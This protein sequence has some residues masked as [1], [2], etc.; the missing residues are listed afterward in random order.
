[1]YLHIGGT[2]QISTKIILGIFS[3]E[4]D[5]MFNKKGHNQGFLAYHEKDLSLECIGMEV[6]RSMIVT[7]EK[8]YLSPISAQTLRLRLKE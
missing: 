3:M 6:P 7:L 5:G 4:E 2:Y 8:I 1:M